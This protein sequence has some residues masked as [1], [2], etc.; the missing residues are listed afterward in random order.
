M[1]HPS[2]V[3]TGQKRISG[4]ILGW[5]ERRVYWAWQGGEK[6]EFIE[7]K[8]TA[9]PAGQLPDDWGEPTMSMCY[10]YIY[11]LHLGL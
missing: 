5:K 6:V 4:L 1:C 11:L 3:H 9:S 7:I 2:S 10:I 8:D